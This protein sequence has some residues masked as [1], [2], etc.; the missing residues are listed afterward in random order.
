MAKTIRIECPV[1]M[2]KILSAAI[3]E[4]V[5]AAYPPGGSECGQVARQALEDAA[6]KLQTDF[7]ANE[8]VYAE[9]SRRLR[10]HLKAAFKY[11]VEQH[12]CQNLLPLLLQLLEGEAVSTEQMATR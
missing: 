8:G 6:K 9:L 2:Q 5:E 3:H 11:Y 12:Q 1:A 10:G 4:Y 7:A